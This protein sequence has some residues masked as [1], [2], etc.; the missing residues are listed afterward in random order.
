M[1]ATTGTG[2]V[3]SAATGTSAVNPLTTKL[4]GCTFSTNAVSSPTASA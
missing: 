1:S 3:A 2:S 4:D